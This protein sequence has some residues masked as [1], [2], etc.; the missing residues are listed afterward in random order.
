MGAPQPLYGTSSIGGGEVGLLIYFVTSF[1]EVLEKVWKGAS[2]SLDA[3]FDVHLGRG[4]VNLVELRAYSRAKGG[5]G[6]NRLRRKVWPLLLG[7]SRYEGGDGEEI[8]DIQ[9]LIDETHKDTAQVHLDTARSLW[10]ESSEKAWDEEK[11]T[12]VRARLTNIILAVIRQNRSI[13]YFQGYHD[14]CSCVLMIM[15]EMDKQEGGDGGDGGIE[16]SDLFLYR[17]TLALT[18]TYFVDSART[19]FTT[20]TRTMSFILNIIR[21]RDPELYNFL[22]AAEI[23]PYFAT[24]WLITWY[25]HDIKSF[26]DV[27]RLFDACLAS[28]PY[29]CL[30]LCAASLLLNRDK[31]LKEECD[32]AILHNALSK[33]VERWG[34]AIEEVIALADQLMES[35]DYQHVLS[36]DRHLARLQWK[37]RVHMFDPAVLQ[38]PATS[39]NRSVAP[40]DWAVMAMARGKNRKSRQHKAQGS[41]V[42]IMV[43]RRL[44]RSLASL[45]VSILETIEFLLCVEDEN[46]CDY[47]YEDEMP[48]NRKI[49]RWAANYPRLLSGR[50]FVLPGD[51]T[52]LL[53][54]LGFGIAT[55][56]THN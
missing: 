26:D 33:M 13:H 28:P 1:G 47:V 52:A 29:Y 44:V 53:V 42:T 19:D 9:R 4:E 37:G 55:W 5:F 27:A 23:P 48:V 7:V 49:L 32:F 21:L 43:H 17:M 40:A 24:S 6:C 18:E 2:M 10:T 20:V 39:F 30:Y 36:L 46:G 16:S 50:V 51:K 45:A 12:Q 14:V 35:L 34:L 3:F 25:S 11:L 41:V 15:T 31:I 54:A 8:V 38:N 22:R 56:L